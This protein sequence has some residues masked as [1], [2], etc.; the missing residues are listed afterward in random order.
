MK[1]ILTFLL[2]LFLTFGCKN[3][4]NN[5][6]NNHGPKETTT[7]KKTVLSPKKFA[8]TL[9]QDAH[10]HIDYAAPSVG[11]R[12]IFGGLLAYGE[13]WQ[14][15]AHNATWLETNK[16]LSIDGK[17]LK[18]GKYG[19]FTI[20]NLDK[21]TLI[22]NRNWDQHGKD[23]YDPNEDVLRFEVTPENTDTFVEQLTYRVERTNETEG[24][25]SL[26]WEKTSVSFP[27]SVKVNE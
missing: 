2:L 18:A 5:S 8:M 15:G 4:D 7:D 12:V 11:G 3:N 17:T 26:S 24:K 22:F 9:I 1:N 13:I 6:H 25:I 21:W 23:E 14:A 20:P 10:I 27:F 19:F 16:D